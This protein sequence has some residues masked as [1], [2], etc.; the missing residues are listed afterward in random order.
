MKFVARQKIGCID[1]GD[2]VITP[3]FKLDAKYVIRTVGSV[4]ED[5]KHGEEQILSSCY[6][7]SLALAKEIGRAHV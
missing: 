4:R 1:F 2:A 3:G 5:G 7:K 6:K